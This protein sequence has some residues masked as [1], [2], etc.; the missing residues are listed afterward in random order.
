MPS[1]HL[2]GSSLSIGCPSKAFWS[3]S[4]FQR[5]YSSTAPDGQDQFLLFPKIND[6]YCYLFQ[7]KLRG[8]AIDVENISLS[9]SIPETSGG[10]HLD[11]TPSSAGFLPN[12]HKICATD[13]TLFYPCIFLKLVLREKKTHKKRYF[14]PKGNCEEGPFVYQLDTD[15]YPTEGLPGD[16]LLL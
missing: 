3:A 16:W 1:C 12:F 9:K 14:P 5:N 11:K 15:G 6:I 8:T 13:I 10:P 2:G 4:E 7:D